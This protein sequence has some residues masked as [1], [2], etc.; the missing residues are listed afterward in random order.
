MRKAA[1]F[2][3]AGIFFFAVSCSWAANFQ[4]AGEA[5]KKADYQQ[6]IVIYRELLEDCQISAPV[7]FNLGNSY[8]RVGNI[9]EAILSYRRAFRLDPRDADIRANLYLARGFVNDAHAPRHGILSRL[10]L[11]LERLTTEELEWLLVALFMLL[12]VSGLYVVFFHVARRR[13]II[14][15]AL[16]AAFWCVLA[17]ST[18]YRIVLE[19]NE[20]VVI[21][22]AEAR[23]EPSNKATVYFNV[24]AGGEVRILRQQEGWAKIERF[25]GKTGW[26][27]AG[28][29]ER[30]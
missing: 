6:A 17:M 24:L 9:G 12:G 22:A 1:L 28:K 29:V 26:I 23:F 10:D 14:L 15:T 19:K 18:A 30:L 7:Y 21:A 27:P 3:L 20:G 25:D 16:G 4:A 11:F 5:Y 13:L 2:F 8:F